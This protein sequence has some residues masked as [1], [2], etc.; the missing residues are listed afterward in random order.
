MGAVKRRPGILAYPI[1]QATAGKGMD[2]AMGVNVEA[3]FAGMDKAQMMAGGQYVKGEGKFLAC[4]KG[5][6]INSGYKGTF[7]IFEFEVLESTSPEDPAG[8]TRSKV[9]ELSAKNKYA[10]SDTKSIV[11]ALMGH[12]PKRVGSPEENPALHAQAAE[13][14]KAACDPGYAA[15][16]GMDPDALVGIN[17]RLE[18]FRKPTRPTVERPQGG[19]FTVHNWLPA[20][21]TP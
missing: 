12:D 4:S 6:K 19:L 5:F 18:T 9:I 21:A 8:C 17:L 16:I 13:I 14:V 1:T 15:K 7:L 11:F 3:M 2:S 20:E 10:F